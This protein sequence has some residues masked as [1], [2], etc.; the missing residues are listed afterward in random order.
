MCGICGIIDYQARPVNEGVLRKMCVAMEH[1]GPDDEGVFFDKGTY[2]VGLG[3]R[4][5]SIIDLSHSGHQP[6][7]NEDKNIWIVFNGEIY[8]FKELQDRLK[9]NGHS[10]KSNTDTETI[11]HLYEEYGSSCVDY[12]RGMF[13]FAIFDK[14][15]D[16]LLLARDR[17]GKKPLLYYN[18]KRCFCFASE[19]NSLIASGLIEKKINK[20]AIDYYLSLGYIP[21]PLTIYENVFKLMPASTL[22]V[23]KGEIGID[24]YWDLDYY[25]KRKISEEDAA[26]ELYT[27]LKEA[28]RIR[29]Y[30]DVPLGA[31]L[32]GG[33][34]S[35]AVV[36]LMSELSTNVKTFSIGF[37]EKKYNE[38]SYARAIAD[39]F[40]TD[41]HEL[42]VRPNAIETLPFLVESYGEPFADSS[43]LPTYYVSRETKKYVTVALTGDGGDESFAGYER[44]QAM[45][46]AD[47]FQK[48][49]DIIKKLAKQLYNHLPDSLDQ[50]NQIRRLKR[51]IAAAGLPEDKRYLRWVSIFDY[52]VK[53]KL[54]TTEFK[55]SLTCDFSLSLIASYL[56]LPQRLNL[57]DRLLMTDTHSYLPN[58]L[59][60]KMD[61]ATMA[62]SL[63]ARSPFLDQH[64]MEF[65]A[66]LPPEYKMKRLI[67]KYILK[68]SL[69]KLLP[70]EILGRKKMG[71]GVPIGTWFRNDL[72]DLLCDT[73]LSRGS[74]SR[75]YFKADTVRTMVNQHI[76][77][78][79]DYAFMLW[80]LLVLELWHK[81]F[82]NG[83]S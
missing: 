56:K 72:K 67:K 31:F 47:T 79:K 55:T 24:Q 17:I 28:V 35:S 61:I 62:N 20:K 12:L 44:Y 2:S 64:V 66:S 45:L 3:H 29:L 81:R 48:F 9:R 27:R 5:L 39:I 36:G 80:T 22:I 33:I 42:I 60:V 43:S 11:L 53:E 50:K 21:A 73:L 18:D 26:S 82:M 34:D 54:Y 71:F 59:L 25:S 68:K 30:S 74:L 14:K 63:E 76:G 10:F 19:F 83:Y 70:R 51:F 23:R 7:C 49:P 41:H 13:A 40:A 38:L 57:L 6:M 37:E 65:A 58:D 32:S 8:N 77:G 15:K 46:I 78:R 4:R 75:G 52:E 16:T 69:E 1:R